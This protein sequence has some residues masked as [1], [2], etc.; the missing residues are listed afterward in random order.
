MGV[1]FSGEP[2]ET[3]PFADSERATRPRHP[4]FQRTL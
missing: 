4:F 3:T 2:W 1:A